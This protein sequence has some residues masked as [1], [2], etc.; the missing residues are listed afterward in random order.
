M[1]ITFVVIVVAMVALSLGGNKN[2]KPVN[3]VQIDKSSF[4]VTS[5]FMVGSIIIIGILV[6]LYTVFW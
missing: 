5:M 3:I 6:A 2:P 4:N 1:T